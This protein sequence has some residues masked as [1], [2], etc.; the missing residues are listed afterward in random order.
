M[1]GIDSSQRINGSEE[2]E[3]NAGKV[4]KSAEGESS[5]DSSAEENNE[6]K[7]GSGSAR[8]YHR[9]KTPRLR[10]T[11]ELHLCFVHAVERL[12]GQERATPKLVLQFMNVKGLSIAHVKSHLQMYRNKK[13]GDPNQVM[14]EKGLAL[15]GGDQLY[16]LSQL[17]LLQSF[18]NRRPSSSLRYNDTSWRG[19]E[20]QS[21]GGPNMIGENALERA[22]HG[23][24]AS[25]AER[26]LGSRSDKSTTKDPMNDKYSCWKMSEEL[27]SRFKR[28]SLDPECDDNIDLNL[29][30]KVKPNCDIHEGFENGNYSLELGDE[31]DSRLSLSL[32]SSPSSS[33]KL[34]FRS[35]EGGHDLMKIQHE[36]T[37]SIL[38]LTL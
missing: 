19:H 29:S 32:S 8:R 22:K 9:S 34:S 33:S 23:L 37:A 25:L 26:L 13:I 10:W 12:G 17:P 36:G 16:N 31:V 28:K 6:Q 27:R 11:P 7:G 35:K 5:S 4:C 20:N 2:E 3:E 14:T 38:D 24:Y 30:L 1:K 21:Y 18:N 15:D